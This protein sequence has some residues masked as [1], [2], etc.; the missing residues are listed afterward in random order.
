VT[1]E[2]EPRGFVVGVGAS[3]GGLEALEGFLRAAPVQ[4]GLTFVIV[5]HLSPDH[6]SHMVELLAKHT[7]MRVVFAEDDM[8]LEPNTVFLIPPKKVLSVQGDALKVVERE[9]GLALPIDVLFRSLAEQWGSRAA[10][11][12]LSGTGSDGTRGSQAVNAA[13]GLVLVQDPGSAKFDGM[14]RAAIATGIVD[15]ILP[16]A[17]MGEK[18]VAYAAR[19]LSFDKPP[20]TFADT[21]GT[22]YERVTG[23]LRRQ[24]GV[25]FGKYK[26]TTITRRIHRRMAVHQVD[27]L[28]AYVD[29]LQTSSRE[30]GSLFK[31]LLISVT[32]FFRDADAFL[33]LAS[34]VVPAIVEKTRPGEP[35]RVWVAGCA[36][37]EEA[38]SIA[39]L[40]E[41]YFESGGRPRDVKIF[42]SDIDRD[43]LDYAGAGI[44]PETI[45]ADISP[46]RLERFFVPHG[47]AYQVSR[48]LRQRVV[49]AN[50]DLTRDPPFGRVSLVSCRNLLIYF[51]QEMQ[52]Q[53][54][55]G[56]R[57]ALR[58]GG[59]LFLGSSETPGEL[60]SELE[61]LSAN[62]KLFRRTDVRPRPGDLVAR[63]LVGAPNVAGAWP[64][65]GG[66]PTASDPRVLEGYDVLVGAYAPPSALITEQHEVVHLFG[67]PSPLL[68]FSSG[69]ASLNLL[70]LLPPSVAAVVGL[71]THRVLRHD[72]EVRYVAVPTEHGLTTVS[73]RPVPSRAGIRLFVASFAIEKATSEPVAATGLV[74]VDAERQIVD[75]QQELQYSRENLQATIEELETS[76]EELQATNEEMVASNEELQSTNEELQSVNEELHTLNTEYQQKITEL[77]RLN[78]DINNLL[79]STRLGSLFLDADLNVTR[80]TPAIK[81]FMNLLDRDIGRSISDITLKFDAGPFLAALHEVTLTRVEVEREVSLPTG[82]A[83]V[84]RVAPYVTEASS[85]AGLVVTVLDVSGVARAERRM[86]RVLDALPNQVALLDRTGKIT[87]VNKAWSDF[88]ERNGGRP[89]ATGVGVDYL[90]ICRRSLGSDAGGLPSHL[91]D[92]VDG[93]IPTL[94]VEYPCHS[95]TEERWFLMQAIGFGGEDGGVVVSHVNITARKKLEFALTRALA[96]KEPS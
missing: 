77:V 87:L 26:P 63:T 40:F 73:V 44:Y 60:G 1:S 19:S 56:F 49:F 39:M 6:K 70:Q 43:A 10:A 25:D 53:V 96:V 18:L 92:L 61:P 78:D 8:L 90:G 16:V 72:S 50:H 68:R 34:E 35:L 14:P 28:E 76:N 42:A 36:T 74:P 47:E 13:G 3:A 65:L 2:A 79:L 52:Q 21:D 55:S 82:Q 41:E 48:F 11:V 62:A 51:N 95:P 91:K 69:T 22:A 5:Q 9:A 24:T 45:A 4:A 71:A 94:E 46:E 64:S 75:L 86:A 57:F 88:A 81:Q 66:K 17:A 37:G 80:F 29:I 32:K 54:I 38:Y 12:V 93:R 30:V 33:T 7:S 84:L 85:H 67:E 89:E 58:P 15:H 27:T 31:E 59:F 20:R 83:F 23:L